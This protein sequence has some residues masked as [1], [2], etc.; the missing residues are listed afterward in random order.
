MVVVVLAVCG[1][2]K[3]IGLE[4]GIVVEKADVRDEIVATATKARWNIFI[5][6]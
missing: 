4:V 3:I 1:E 6:I 2:L 5:V